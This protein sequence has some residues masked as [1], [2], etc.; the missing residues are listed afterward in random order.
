MIR[1]LALDIDGTLM[2]GDLLIS[3]RSRYAITAAQER[4]VVVTLAT[5]R[6]FNFVVPFARDLRITAPLIC[7]QGGLVQS[8]DS[9][10]PLYRATM[11]PSLVREMLEW[12]AQRGMRV[13]LYADDDVFLTERQHSDSFY[14]YML[15]ERLV[16][17]NDLSTVVEQHEPIKFIVFVEPSEAN[18]IQTELQQRF[19]GQVEIT[20]SHELIVE[21]NPLGVS[22]GNALRRLAAHLE[23][24]QT[25]VM[26]VGDQDNDIPMIV[27]ASLGVA[28]GNDSP[29]VKAVADWIAPPLAEDGAAVAIEQFLLNT[30]RE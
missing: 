16:W 12:Q 23:I 14:H 19:E 1:L 13:V 28:M 10:V 29:A 7:Y 18:S 8:A 24:P 26:A 3:P 21:G 11:E 2:D 5:G 22:K 27:W 15:G 20:R 4:G 17:V 25:Q 9:D 30:E 6:M